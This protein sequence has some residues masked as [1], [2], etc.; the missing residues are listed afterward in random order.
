M[1][2]IAP[3]LNDFVGKNIKTICANGYAAPHDNHCAHFVSHAMGF[4][5]GYTCQT[6]TTG[7]SAGANLRVHELFSHCL[8]VGRWTDKPAD[9]TGCLVF[10]TAVSHVNLATKVMANVP[11]KHVG[12]FR[13][14]TIWHYS[15]LHHKVVT[16]Q[17]S[18]FVHHYHGPGIEL[19]YGQF[20]Q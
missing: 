8:T 18:Q 17:P 2:S 11:Q 20:P 5:F 13:N 10:V 4:Q 15:N 6:A 7:K 16:E 12:V 3:Q 1:A 19:F 9:L 14:G